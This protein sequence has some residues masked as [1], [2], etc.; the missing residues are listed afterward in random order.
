[1]FIA[2]HLLFGLVLGLA[3]ARHLGDR[4]LIGFS[5]L[6]AVLPD[7]IDKPVGHILLADSLDSGRIFAHGLLFLVLLLAL[8]IAVER[9]Q[10]SFAL[11]AVAAGGLSHQVLDT[12]WTLPVTWCFPLLGPYQPYEYTN[13]FGNALLAEASSLSEWVFL[14]ASAG[15]A[16]TE[17][18]WSQ[19]EEQQNQT[20]AERLAGFASR[21][22]DVSVTR[23]VTRDRAVRALVEQSQ[24]AQLVV[25]GS[26]GRGGFAGMVLGSTSRALLQAAPCPVMVVRP[27]AHA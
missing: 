17:D 3:L 27:E 24:G 25:V 4:R 7:L 2:C 21:Y 19:L 13:Y 11:L 12:M 23:H 10:G 18:D 15:I 8:G 1:M 9:R 26:H 14:F 20:L 5:A 22:P 16:L 6:G